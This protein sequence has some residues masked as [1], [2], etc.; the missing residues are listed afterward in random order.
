M[1]L[2]IL[3]SGVLYRDP[4]ARVSATGK[5]YTVAKLRAD[6]QDDASVWVSLI[7]FGSMADELAGLKAHDSV[8]VS[9]KGKLTVWLNKA[10]EP[11]AGLGLVVDSLTPLAPKPKP[12]GDRP[13]SKYPQHRPLP[14]AT[15]TAPD[16]FDDDLAEWRT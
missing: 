14:E 4:E 8:S 7:A 2:R 3:A 9:G 16:D 6:A 12:K 11:A 1:S 5:A 15:D 10:G 13:P